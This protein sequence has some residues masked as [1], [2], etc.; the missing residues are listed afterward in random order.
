MQAGY[1]TAKKEYN[2]S[3]NRAYN[4]A[5]A[6][7]SPFKKHR[8][9]ND[10]RWNDVAEK[11]ETLRK[12]KDAAKAENKLNKL[13]KR[14]DARIRALNEDIDSFRGLEAGLFTKN[15]KMIWSPNDVKSMVDST[16]AIRDKYSRQVTDMVNRLSQDYKVAYDVTTGKYN[17][18]F[19]D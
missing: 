3:F 19:K 15:G 18:R 8:Q 9:A 16:K 13:G 2:K 14:N 12:Y 10:E 5:A 6:A 4:K 1:K 7:Y 11:A 17:L